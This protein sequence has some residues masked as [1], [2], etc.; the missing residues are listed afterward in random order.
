MNEYEASVWLGSI[1]SV[2]AAKKC[3]LYYNFG[4]AK[5]VYDADIKELCGY[6]KISEDTAERIESYRNGYDSD[7]MARTMESDNI[8]FTC[9]GNDDYPKELLSIYDPPFGLYYTGSFIKDNERFVAMVGA[10]R[11]S[12]YGRSMAERIAKEIVSRNIG[13]VSGMALGIDAASHCGALEG[14][15]RTIAV[16]G[17]GPDVCYPRTNE[18]IYKKIS[19]IG[20]IISEYAPKTQPMAEFFPQRNRIISGLSCATIVIEARKKSGSL[21]TANVALKQNRDVWAL[22]GRVGDAL[23]EGCNELIGAG[24]G[25][26]LD[27]DRF[28]EDTFAYVS[29]H[30]NNEDRQVSLSDL[31]E[32]NLEK[33]EL[34][35][36]SCLDFYPKDI[37]MVQKE[38]DMT[39]FSIFNALQGLSSKGLIREC[40]KN[41]Y[42]RIK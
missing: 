13:I 37:D 14:N 42:E 31:S 22:P 5:A 7:Y 1:P 33:E 19:E 27:T 15:G 20:C 11:C 41:H 6:G 24:A 30:S 32:L 21:I 4:S 40:F 25:I 35:V 38:S 28:L 23:S 16:L 26:F 8:G 10:R 9:I 39:L 36:Y 29:A 2:S 12:A 3:R 18:R 34:L 17:C